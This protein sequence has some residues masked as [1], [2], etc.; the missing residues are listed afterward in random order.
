MIA[1][2]KKQYNVIAINKIEVTV[3]GNDRKGFSFI[4]IKLSQ[5]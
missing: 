5:E 2:K 3:F 4:Q 1:P